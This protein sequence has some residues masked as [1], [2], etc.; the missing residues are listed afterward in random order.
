MGF[1]VFF[2]ISIYIVL[3]ILVGFS[4]KV[5]INTI[6]LN[7]NFKKQYLKLK[8]VFKIENDKNDVIKQQLLLVDNLYESLFN[9]LFRITKE[10]LLIQK[11]YFY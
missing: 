9:R 10:L 6:I 8:E 2:S 11:E 7:K 5:Y 3:C 1:N 4:I